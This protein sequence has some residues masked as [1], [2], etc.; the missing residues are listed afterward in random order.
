[1]ADACGIALEKDPMDLVKRTRAG[2]LPLTEHA[3]SMANDIAAGRATE[4]EFLTGYLVRKARAVGVP[5]PVCETVYR[6][7][8]GLEYA[9]ASTVQPSSGPSG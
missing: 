1:M 7:A 3:G 5:V 8:K 6:L 2:T 4:L 9:A